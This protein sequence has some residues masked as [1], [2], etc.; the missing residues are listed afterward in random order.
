MTRTPKISLDGSILTIEMGESCVSAHVDDVQALAK[1]MEGVG[2]LVSGGVL[3]S[4]NLKDAPPRPAEF[5]SGEVKEGGYSS[6]RTKKR[7]KSRKNV[8]NALIIW[9]RAHPG[10]HSE[11]DLLKTVIAHRM[12]DAA[13][14]RAL[15]IALGRKKDE[16][17]VTDGLGN[18]CL[19]ED[20]RPGSLETLKVVKQEEESR[21]P[22]ADARWDSSNAQEIARARR[23]L[24]GL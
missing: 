13:P 9:L 11:E 2:L 14:H 8:G 7:R 1:I 4:M 20:H 22:G 24:L 23:N 16:V 10:W 12:S 19:K 3:E 15:K 17:F 18:W 6:G 21:L 5:D